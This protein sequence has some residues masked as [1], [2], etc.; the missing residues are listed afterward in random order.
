MGAMRPWHIIVLVI[1]LI[2][3]FGASKL[4]DIAQNIGKSAKVLKKEMKEL[5]EDDQPAAPPQV[6]NQ[7][8]QTTGQANVQPQ[9]VE[10]DPKSPN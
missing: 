6:T 7:P 4:P 1:V 2:L 8:S 5:Q 10:E 9:N 3:V